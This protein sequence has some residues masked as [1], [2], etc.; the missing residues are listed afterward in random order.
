MD[1]STNDKVDRL[2]I[3]RDNL[4]AELLAV[5]NLG[6][7]AIDMDVAARI[8]NSVKCIATANEQ[9]AITLEQLEMVKNILDA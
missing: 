8:E 6:A 5:L 7:G 4:F 3:Y 2:T 1:D 9:I